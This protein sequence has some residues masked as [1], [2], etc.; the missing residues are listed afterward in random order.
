MENKLTEEQK[1]LILEIGEQLNQFFQTI[2]KNATVHLVSQYKELDQIFDDKINK[3][4][5]TISDKQRFTTQEAADIIGVTRS[6]LNMLRW[7]GKGPKFLKI[8][9]KVI[10]RKEDLEE[11]E[12]DKV[13]DN[14][15]Q[16]SR[17]PKYNENLRY[18][19]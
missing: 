8:G 2:A 5:D 7:E 6:K 10:Y 3:K 11:F 19:R 13:Y 15:S 12:K 16:Y 18:G 9:S 14:T 17:K 4:K 1:T